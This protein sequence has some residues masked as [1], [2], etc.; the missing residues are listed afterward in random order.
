MTCA[1]SAC[2]AADQ[3]GR[4]RRRSRCVRCG[5]I[6]RSTLTD[7]ANQR[8]SLEQARSATPRRR[9]CAARQSSRSASTPHGI[10]QRAMVSHR[11]GSS[12]P[13]PLSCVRRQD[14]RAARRRSVLPRSVQRLRDH[15]HGRRNAA[16]PAG[17]DSASRCCQPAAQRRRPQARS[18][19]CRTTREH[20]TQPQWQR[21]RSGGGSAQ[22]LRQC[23]HVAG[24]PRCPAARLAARGAQATE[25]TRGRTVFLD[26][27][28][29]T[30]E[31]AQRRCAR[32]GPLRPPQRDGAATAT[33]QRLVGDGV[34]AAVVQRALTPRTGHR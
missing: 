10:R 12:R 31:A 13:N 3:R 26:S 25:R 6:V 17:K 23:C 8:I 4:Q 19:E 27:Q 24:E 21:A 14:S 30:A 2:Y 18:A 9:R 29:Q 34:A 28:R 7:D 5:A 1:A 20:S 11:V 32:S 15:V 16:Q 22:Y 33:P